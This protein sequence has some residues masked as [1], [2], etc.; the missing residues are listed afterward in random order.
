LTRQQSEFTEV[1][2]ESNVMWQGKLEETYPEVNS[3][4]T[5]NVR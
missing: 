2:N 1:W 4:D 3:S 5:W